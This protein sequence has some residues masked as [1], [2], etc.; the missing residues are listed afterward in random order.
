MERREFF[1]KLFERILYVF[2]GVLLSYPVFSFLSFKKA[3]TRKVVFKDGKGIQDVVFKDR[4]FLVRAHGSLH[5]LSARCTHL[6]CTL[7]YD[8]LSRQFRCPCHGSRFDRSGK[9]IAGPARKHLQQLPMKM[10]KNG[11]VM[12]TVT[13]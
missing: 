7:N 9:R 2:S 13:L 10:E 6:G 3:S 8:P 12:V 5:A 1:S 11:D 4:V